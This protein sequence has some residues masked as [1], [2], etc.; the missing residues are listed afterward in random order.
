MVVVQNGRSKIFELLRQ[1]GGR[2][3][4]VRIWWDRVLGRTTSGQEQAPF[5]PILI[6]PNHPPQ[7]KLSI[8]DQH[9]Q[10]RNS[11]QQHRFSTNQLCI[12]YK[13]NFFYKQH[14]TTLNNLN[15][16]P[17]ISSFYRNSFSHSQKP[18]LNTNLF[19][20]NSTQ[21]PST[22]NLNIVPTISSILQEQLPTA[23]HKE[24]SPQVPNV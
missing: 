17:A 19:F 21:P 7:P 10:H 11:S 16:V 8:N 12:L 4:I 3:L 15:L 1:G 6:A 14:P 13:L 24:S 9:K 22:N 2:Q 18:R 5:L 20:C 23:T